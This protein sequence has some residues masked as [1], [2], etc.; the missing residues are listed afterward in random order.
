MCKS[1]IENILL[2]KLDDELSHT[3]QSMAFQNESQYM[4]NPI[5]TQSSEK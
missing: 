5:F 1:K 4:S 2:E 3:K